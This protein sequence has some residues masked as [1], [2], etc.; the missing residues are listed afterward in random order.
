MGEGGG[1][2]KQKW[3]EKFP[4]FLTNNNPICITCLTLNII[5]EKVQVFG[6]QTKEK[7]VENCKKISNNEQISSVGSNLSGGSC[8]NGWMNMR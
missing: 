5:W 2:D 8:G 3:Q 6:S 7:S 4:F 1:R